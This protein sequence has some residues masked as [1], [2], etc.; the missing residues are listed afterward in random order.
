[1]EVKR[2]IS[3]RHLAVLGILYDRL[4]GSPVRWVVVGSLGLAL[5]GIP[6]T[7]HDIDIRTDKAGAYEMARLF[8]D[9]VTDPVAF[10]SAERIRSYFGALRIKGVRVEIMG[11]VQ[12]RRE[13]GGWEASTAFEPYTRLI[14]IKQ[15][16]V[17]VMSVEHELHSYR[18][19]RRPDKVA[20]LTQWLRRER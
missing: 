14:T 5:Q 20:L 1:V 10:S 8:S 16:R 6:V 2:L 15:M 11:A 13:A 19:L 3:P 12:M 17:P 7:V 18:K 4:Q 9:V